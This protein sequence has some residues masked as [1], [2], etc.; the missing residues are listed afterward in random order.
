MTYK[1]C[2]EV[3]TEATCILPLCKWYKAA[4]PAPIVN[5]ANP[6]CT[7]PADPPAGMTC[8]GFYFDT[9]TCAYACP[10]TAPTNSC[11]A[12]AVFA[13]P[14]GMTCSMGAPFF[15]LPSCDY[16]CPPTGSC[17]MVAATGTD[18]TTATTAGTYP[19]TTDTCF[20]FKSAAACPATT[21]VW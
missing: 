11:V 3:K 7:K 13:P 1:N 17:N 19:T 8:T 21:C 16:I 6:T 9:S 20:N 5:P 4:D 2:G 18:A 14:A 15:D 10:T 12:P